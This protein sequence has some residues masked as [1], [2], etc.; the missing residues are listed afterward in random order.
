MQ[1][2]LESSRANKTGSV[3]FITLI[4]AGLLGTALGSYLYWVRSQNLLTTESH[5]WNGALVVAE[6]G[7]EEAL[8]QL[9]TK[10]GTNGNFAA[11]GWGVSGGIYGP[12]DGGTPRVL[13]V[14][15]VTNGSYSA[16]ITRDATTG[17]P[18]VYS[19]GYT[20]VPLVGRLITRVVKV[21]TDTTPAFAGAMAA[22]NNITF[23]GT[24]IAIDSYDSMDNAHSTPTGM[25]DP[26][27]RKAGGD[28]ASISGVVSVGNAN[29]NGKVKTGPNGSYNIGPTGFAGDLPWTG[30]GI[31]PGWYANDFNADFKDAALPDGFS[32][33][34]TP[35]PVGT[36]LYVLG[37]FDYTISGNLAMGAKETMIVTGN[38]RLYVTGDVVMQGQSSIWIAPGA[39]LEI[40]VAGATAK[41]TEVNT[42]G[43]ANSYKY[44]GLPTNTSLTWSGNATYVGTVYAPQAAFDC[45]GG[46]STLYDYQGACVVK[47]VN[48]NGHFNFHY[49]ENLKRR[50]PMSG[51]RM[52]SWREL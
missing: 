11:N 15:S 13:R 42:A 1:I 4:L 25:Y 46:G 19:T 38:A 49:D 16:I 23:K 8:A 40:Y 7:V 20:T 37:G 9:N 22:L 30:P 2:R 43:N 12:P 6:A 21:E 50:G 10:F 48:L 29:V 26:A 52:K 3:L 18:I 45:G 5:A 33:G 51:F 39:S 41:F 47:S 44:F 31:Q 32:L 34:L 17:Y 28:V 36:N 14:G 35:P 27:T 24:L